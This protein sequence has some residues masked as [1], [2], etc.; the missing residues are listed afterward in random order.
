MASRIKP[1]IRTRITRKK[2][3]DP[4]FGSSADL[5]DHVLPTYED[6]IRYFLYTQRKLN[7]GPRKNIP[8]PEIANEVVQRVEAIWEKATLPVVSRQQ[9]VA[10]L[11]N[12]HGKFMDIKKSIKKK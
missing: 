7:K 2:I 12:Y 5:R 9:C 1:K 10:V 8:F 6:V 11:K 3:R 4:V